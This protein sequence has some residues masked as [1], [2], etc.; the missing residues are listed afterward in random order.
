VFGLESFAVL[1]HQSL[2]KTRPRTHPK[3]NSNV[4]VSITSIHMAIQ[5]YV[6]TKQGESVTTQVSVTKHQTPC[7]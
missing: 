7:V 1:E 6:A 3:Y 4:T 2:I 5:E